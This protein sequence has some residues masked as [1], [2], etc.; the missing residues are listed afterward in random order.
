MKNRKWTGQQKLQIVLEGLK[1]RRSISELCAEHEM[2]Q[3]QYYKW[4]DQFH[5]NAHQLFALNPD[6]KTERLEAK[7]KKLTGLIGE[8][9]V[10]L[11]K[12]EN[13]LEWLDS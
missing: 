9:T 2:S 3:S 5:K 12:T 7:V 1:G 4:R 8:L 10:D 6:K 11:K 13:E